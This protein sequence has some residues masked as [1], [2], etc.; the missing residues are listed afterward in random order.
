M[1]RRSAALGTATFL[2]VPATVAGLVPWWLTSWD[3]SHSLGLAARIA[4]V[5]LIVAGTAALLSAF[6]RFVIDGIGTPAPV[7]PT[8]RLVVSGLYRYVRNPMYT[9]V[10]AA[11]TGQ[12][13]VFG[14]PALLVYAG[15][16]AL[17]MHTFVVACEEP[18]LRREFGAEYRAYCAAVPRWL[19]RLRR[20]PP[21]AGP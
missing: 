1:P 3:V 8:E 12:A 10:V 11:I 19:P 7:A 6:V 13:M 16:V 4:G 20:T 5:C 15:A 14:D 18:T 21:A 2:V 17:M 9:A